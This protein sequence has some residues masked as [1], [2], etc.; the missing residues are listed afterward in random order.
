MAAIVSNNFRVLNA[1]NF[2]EDIAGSAV[3]VSIGKSDV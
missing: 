3:Y 2:K 1:Q